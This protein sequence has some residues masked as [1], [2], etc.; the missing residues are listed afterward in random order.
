MLGHLGRDPYEGWWLRWHLN[1]VCLLF[2]ATHASFSGL[3]LG[4]LVPAWEGD[5][6]HGLTQ[7]GAVATAYLLRQWME[8]R[9]RSVGRSETAALPQMA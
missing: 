7:F 6:L 8:Q 5:V 9:Y 3:V 1:G 2:A 4:R